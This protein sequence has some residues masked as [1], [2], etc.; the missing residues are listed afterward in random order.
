MNQGKISQYLDCAIY[1]DD[2]GFDCST[3]SETA[4][5]LTSKC[6]PCMSDGTPG[7]VCLALCE[8]SEAVDV[9]LVDCFCGEPG[10]ALAL[11]EIPPVERCHDRNDGYR[12]RCC[13][14]GIFRVE[15]GLCER[16]LNEIRLRERTKTISELLKRVIEESKAFRTPDMEVL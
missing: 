1:R 8:E 6:H 7:K 16:P 10:V 15:C 13:D 3:D 9:L 14:D 2:P 4:A 12:L 5:Y 11:V